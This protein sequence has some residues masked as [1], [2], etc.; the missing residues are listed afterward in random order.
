MSK[1]PTSK[2]DRDAFDMT[3]DQRRQLQEKTDA[4]VLAAALDDPDAQPIPQER[5]AKMGRPLVKIVRHKLKLSREEF[6]EAYG[7]PL[8]TLIS[9]ERQQTEPTQT[10]L[11]YLRLI[12]RNPEVAKLVAA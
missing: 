4:E 5:L 11:T 1:T 10:E 7:I 6:A 9:W 3:S 12:E 2:I 8:A